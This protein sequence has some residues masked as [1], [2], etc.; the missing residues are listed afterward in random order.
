[1]ADRITLHEQNGDRRGFVAAEQCDVLQREGKGFAVYSRRGKLV[2]F[3]LYGYG[4]PIFDGREGAI[5]MHDAS[6][7]TQPSIREGGQLLGDQ[8]ATREFRYD[9]SL[10]W[11]DQRATDPRTRSI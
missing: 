10:E 6:R 2:R 11:W 3:I 4:R 9:A 8:R 1:M 5:R 7:T